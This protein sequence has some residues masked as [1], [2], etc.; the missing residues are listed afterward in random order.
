MQKFLGVKNFFLV[1]SFSL[2]FL[3]FPHTNCMSQQNKVKQTKQEKIVKSDTI[4]KYIDML[5]SQQNKI[6][7]IQIDMLNTE[8]YITDNT[9]K[10]QA[11]KVRDVA[12]ELFLLLDTPSSMMGLYYLLMSRDCETSDVSKAFIKRTLSG[13]QVYCD[14][15]IRSIDEILAKTK[16][17]AI[18]LQCD[19]LKTEIRSSK[20]VLENLNRLF[21]N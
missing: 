12:Q 13:S 15:Y 4:K 8:T 5:V 9:E 20:E 21:V 16:Q 17:P 14:I 7:Q 11:S 1:L 3:L 19:K 2:L 6:N 18:S 10:Q